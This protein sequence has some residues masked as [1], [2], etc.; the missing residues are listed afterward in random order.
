M[1]EA[2]LVGPDPVEREL[3]E[4]GKRLAADPDF[5]TWLEAGRGDPER[6]NARTEQDVLRMIEAHRP[7]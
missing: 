2:A 5:Q 1:S 3:V 4:R 6:E 7:S